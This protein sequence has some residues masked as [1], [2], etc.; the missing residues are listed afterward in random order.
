[1]DERVGELR[2]NGVEIEDT[3]A[4]AFK[5]RAARVIVTAETSAWARTAGAVATGYA[6][7]VIG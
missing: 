6:T 4:E 2:I 1:M 5:M 7:S 3:Y